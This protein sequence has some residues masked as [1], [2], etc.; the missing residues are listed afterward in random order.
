MLVKR[1]GLG[2]LALIIGGV[3][4]FVFGFVALVPMSGST[5]PFWLGLGFVVVTLFYSL[6]A[7]GLRRIDFEWSHIYA[8]LMCSP[9]LL[10]GVVA[11]LNGTLDLMFGLAVL[12]MTGIAVAA[13]MRPLGAH[14]GKASR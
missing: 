2:I 14:T 9:L 4:V 5:D 11:G 10:F 8:L 7:Y 6:I 3:G 13:A 12:L 1:I